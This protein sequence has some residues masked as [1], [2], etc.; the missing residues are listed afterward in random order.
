MREKQV[1]TN[2]ETWIWRRDEYSEE[3]D[4]LACLASAA[5]YLS[6]CIS[7]TSKRDGEFHFIYIFFFFKNI[8]FHFLNIVIFYVTSQFSAVLYKNIL[9]YMCVL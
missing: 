9:C 5:T 4:A 1:T 2:D 8:I 6:L 3:S 7:Q